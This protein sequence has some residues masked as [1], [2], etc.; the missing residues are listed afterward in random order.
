VGI[1]NHINKT[2]KSCVILCDDIPCIWSQ[3]KRSLPR[4]LAG[5]EAD[6]ILIPKNCEN[7]NP[8]IIVMSRN[9]ILEETKLND[10]V[11]RP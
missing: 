3:S 2:I 5:G 1:R 11:L 7:I 10:I 8:K 6:N 4:H 9:E